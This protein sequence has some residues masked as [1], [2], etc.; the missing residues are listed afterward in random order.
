MSEPNLSD[1]P[2]PFEESHAL[3]FPAR[4]QRFPTSYRAHEV[5]TIADWIAGG[6]S[7]SV[8][9][10]PGTGRATLLDF[11][12]YRPDVLKSYLASSLASVA[13]I[14]VDLNILPDH[15]PATF[16]RVILRSFYQIR[17][18]FTQPLDKT[19]AELY[20]RH[21][22]ARDPFLAQSALLELL[23]LCQV[24]EMRVV[25]VLNRFDQF[26]RVA[27]PEMVRTLRALRDNFQGTL[28]YVVGMRQE[29]IYLSHLQSIDPLYRIL[30]AH[31]CW[32]GP[33]H[34]VDA[35]SMI[36]H[37]LETATKVSE[38]D[39]TALWQLTGGYPVLIELASQWW[40]ATSGKLPREQWLDKLLDQRAIR[41]RLE[42]IWDNL[43]QEE[44][45]A[46]SELQKAQVRTA[47]SSKPGKA[48]S[49]GR[50][51]RRNVEMQPTLAR[52]QIKGVCRDTEQGWYIVSE[53]LAHF[54][55]Q[56]E[57]RGRGRVWED[58]ETEAIYQ[59]RALIEGL[60]PL[61][62]AVL[63]FLIKNPQL[64]HSH[65]EIIEAAWPDDVLKEGVTT[66]ALYQVVRGIR[67]KLEP[68]P[69]KPVYL[70]N[71]RGIRGGGYQFFP[72]G[73]PGPV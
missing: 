50:R 22:A 55:A 12:C 10:L 58:E 41:H 48:A 42:R 35:R 43:S 54:I 24:Q 65:T 68:N 40:F 16:Y 15:S 61:E 26:C 49:A 4:W 11:L 62:K 28:N 37:K 63:H 9:G 7:G 1:L 70:T 8:I 45:L 18:Q 38:A 20:R 46:L 19:I 36:A 60:Q 57:G 67:K 29:V 33:L 59:D 64:R 6:N 56:V 52:L 25:W 21:E 23:T 72:E 73:R 39:M 47:Q 53:L 32:V 5:Q 31:V 14:P 13:L 34:E 3:A 69:G 44:Q 71:W 27:T 51:Q 30:D 66:D 17:R 2:S